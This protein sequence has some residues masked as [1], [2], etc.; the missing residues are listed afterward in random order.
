MKTYYKV[1]EHIASKSIGTERQR[2][3]AE[4]TLTII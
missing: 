3:A 1:V 4:I 2:C